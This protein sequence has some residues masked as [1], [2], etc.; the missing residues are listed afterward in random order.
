MNKRYGLN[1]FQNG[2]FKAT[3]YS[4]EEAARNAAPQIISTIGKKDVVSLF[5]VRCTVD[6]KP[7]ENNLHVID[8]WFCEHTHSDE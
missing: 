4:S 2:M 6:G 5:W 3:L 1:V 7:A 8:E